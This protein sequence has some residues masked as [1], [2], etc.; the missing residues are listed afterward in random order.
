M[1]KNSDVLGKPKAHL[2]PARHSPPTGL[3]SGLSWACSMSKSEQS[4]GSSSGFKNIINPIIPVHKIIC[5]QCTGT[6]YFPLP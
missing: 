6:L 1:I 4:L 2:S 3:E 5:K